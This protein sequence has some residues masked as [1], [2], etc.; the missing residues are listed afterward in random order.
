[1]RAFRL[2]G[3]PSVGLLALILVA[4]GQVGQPLGGATATLRPVARQ[5][6]TTTTPYQGTPLPHGWT[7]IT[8]TAAIPYSDQPGF[9]SQAELRVTAGC[10]PGERMVGAGYAATDVFEYNATIASSYPIND[11]SWSVTGGTQAGIQLD[12]YCLHG[13]HLP[14]VVIISGPFGAVACPADS[15][16]LAEGFGPPAGSGSE[17]TSYALCATSGVQ[18]GSRTTSSV[19]F[20]SSQN[21][22]NA[23]SASARCPTGQIALGG[24]AT[25]VAYFASGTNADFAG[26]TITG[27]GNGSGAVFAMC[28]RLL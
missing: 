16:A 2:L 8:Y 6:P 3:R 12:V 27:G 1:M 19:V 5:E 28:V 4:C 21:G 24:G 18:A 25:G 13:D 15:V 14:T 26:W 11:H 7:L 10:H 17:Q 22:Y 23:A 9:T 20:D